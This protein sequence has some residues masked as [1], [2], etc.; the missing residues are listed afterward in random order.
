MSQVVAR[1]AAAE[2]RDKKSLA[3]QMEDDIRAED[4]RL[5]LQD[6]NT[7][8]QVLWEKKEAMEK[9]EAE[10]SLQLLLQFLHHAR[11]FHPFPHYVACCLVSAEHVLA[12]LGNLSR[13]KI[14][15]IPLVPCLKKGRK[16]WSSDA[17]VGSTYN[18]E[19]VA[20]YRSEK[21]RKLQELQEELSTLDADIQQV[22]GHAGAAGPAAGKSSAERLRK[23]LREAQEAPLEAAPAAALQDREHP[24]PNGHASVGENSCDVMFESDVTQTLF[25]IRIPHV[26][27]S[28]MLSGIIRSLAL[29]TVESSLNTCYAQAGLMWRGITLYHQQKGACCRRLLLEQRLPAFP[30]R[31]CTLQHVLGESSAPSRRLPLRH[32]TLDALLCCWVPLPQVNNSQHPYLHLT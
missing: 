8:L 19:H 23:R 30:P 15:L 3:M 4:S 20:F 27:R 18:K 26:S 29:N 31:P 13:H 5:S 24:P 11:C 9:Q 7:L 28:L 6:V 16:I 12:S 25:A 2:E 22:Q 10:A 14:P 1:V 21:N 17:I 32:C